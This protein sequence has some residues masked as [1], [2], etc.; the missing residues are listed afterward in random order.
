MSQEEPVCPKTRSMNM[1]MGKGPV[2][3]F[4]YTYSTLAVYFAAAV[5]PAI[6]LMVFINSRDKVDKEP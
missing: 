4:G 5:V 1:F 2:N 6:I 3:M